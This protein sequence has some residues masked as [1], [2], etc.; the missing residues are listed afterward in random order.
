MR[1]LNY[2]LFINRLNNKACEGGMVETELRV[3][4]TGAG[5]GFR[6]G[7]LAMA[8]GTEVAVSAS[9]DLPLY[10]RESLI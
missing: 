7:L 5:A 2:D 10:A 8:T 4:A 6:A 1:P 3:P 9:A